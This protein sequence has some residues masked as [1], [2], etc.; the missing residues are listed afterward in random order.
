MGK[1][2]WWEHYPPCRDNFY[3]TPSTN[4]KSWSCYSEHPIMNLRQQHF[5][6]NVITLRILWLLFGLSSTR[7]LL[8][9]RHTPGIKFL[10]EIIIVMREWNLLLCS[11]IFSKKWF[12][13]V[14]AIWFTAILHAVQYLEM[15][16]ILSY[17]TAATPTTVRI[18]TFLQGTT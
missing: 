15:V 14:A 7:R 11:W 2:T 12:R 13:T 6:K 10:M 17:L 4:P 16:M 3:T 5:T 9:F 1:G 8:D 18:V